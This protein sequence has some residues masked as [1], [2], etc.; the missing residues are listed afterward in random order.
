MHLA[1]ADDGGDLVL[2]QV[3]VEPQLDDAALTLGQALEQPG[4][5]I[6]LEGESYV[7]GNYGPGNMQK[8]RLTAR[9]V[10]RDF[11]PVAVPADPFLLEGHEATPTPEEAPPADATA[12]APPAEAPPAPPAEPGTATTTPTITVTPKPQLTPT[13]EPDDDDGPPPT[14]AAPVQTP[15][16][17]PEPTPQP[18]EPTPALQGGE[19]TA[20][21][22]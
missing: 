1:D 10:P 2:G 15:A 12:P 4:D 17:T 14:P 11:N 19:P 13:P 22:P 3:L 7:S 20:T 9:R 21:G 16:V 5:G 6:P 18:P 8:I